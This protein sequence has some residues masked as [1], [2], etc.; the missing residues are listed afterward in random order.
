MNDNYNQARLPRQKEEK[1]TARMRLEPTDA[2]V[3]PESTNDD[4]VIVS[5][6]LVR[7]EFGHEL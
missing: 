3:C 6:R 7:H 5:S 4:R 2:Y 1:R